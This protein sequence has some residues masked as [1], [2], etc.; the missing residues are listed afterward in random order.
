MNNFQAEMSIT[1]L[2]L[3]ELQ[4]VKARAVTK[5]KCKQ[6]H[7]AEKQYKN[8]FDGLVFGD[9]LIYRTPFQSR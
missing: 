8:T 2:L 1:K 9:H 6:H 7:C 5:T 4:E 3:L